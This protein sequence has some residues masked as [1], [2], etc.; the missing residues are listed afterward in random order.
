MN[1]LVFLAMAFLQSYQSNVS[2][3]AEGKHVDSV[4]KLS[5]TMALECVYPN[6]ASI[7]QI[8]WQKEENQSKSSIAVFRLP[9]DLHIESNYKARILVTNF[10]SN[11]KTLIFSKATEED[12][13]FYRCTFH[14]FPNGIWEK[15]IHVVQSGTF[16]FPNL[17]IHHLITKPGENVTFEYRSNSDVAANRV[18]WERVQSDCIDF[19]IQCEDSEMPVY[20]SDYQNRVDCISASSIVLWHVTASDF[21]MYRFSYNKVNGENG[22][23]WIKLMINS[24]APLFTKLHMI[25][26]GSAAF[27]ILVIVILLIYRSCCVA[28]K[29]KRIKKMRDYKTSCRQHQHQ[30]KNWAGQG[31]ANTRQSPT[32][33]E[34]PIYVNCKQFMQK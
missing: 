34:D 14:A 19:I 12:A 15:M 30:S 3:T 10:T 11:N 32:A 17:S 13:G 21:G 1:C 4:V 2:L 18:T 29:R 28:K 26:I 22:I 27:L 33:T 24:H 9:Y 31:S 16:E 8:E 6:N 7:S 23:G 5:R 25:F 20:G